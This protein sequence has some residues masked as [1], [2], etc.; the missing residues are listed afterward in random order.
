MTIKTGLICEG[1]GTK[2]AYTCGVLQCF[3]DNDIDFPYTVGISAGAEVLLPFVSK[4]R[5]RLRIS[6]VD[7]AS[8]PKAIGVSPLLH[9]RGVFGIDHVCKFIEEHA[10]LDYAAFMKNPTQLDIG[11][12]NMDTNEVEYFGKEYFD[13]IEQRLMKASCSLFLLTRPVKF[14]NHTYMDAGLV[15]M[16]PIEQS[17]RQGM[18]KHVF[19]ST[20]EENYV[21]KPAPGWQIQLARLMY[22]GNKQIR[23]YLRIRHE[24]YNRQWGIVKKLEEEG[25]AIVLRPSADYGVTRYTSDKEL[26]QR[27]FDLGYEDTEKRLT[28]I[29]E[30]MES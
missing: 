23:E 30:F 25:K 21:R 3:L 5:E 1:G 12:Y 9:E 20:K 18:D 6:G 22:P 7:A 8:D 17:I 4:Q 28:M 19:I 11:V 29:R 15:D 16:I 27:W 13:P 14:R 24:N 10:P 26:L 2:A